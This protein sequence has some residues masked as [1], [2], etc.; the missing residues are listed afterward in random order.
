M[1]RMSSLED[2]SK[3]PV[4][5][6]YVDGCMR[7]YSPFDGYHDHDGEEV[8]RR[9]FDSSSTHVCSRHA[10]RMYI[11]TYNKESGRECWVCS[12]DCQESRIDFVTRHC[13]PEETAEM[14]QT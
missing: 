10:L 14:T 12:F 4:R 7:L 2:Q 9:K 13:L 3:S 6:C 5:C 11:A 1:V 8:S